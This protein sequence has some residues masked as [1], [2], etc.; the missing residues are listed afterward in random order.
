MK[1]KIKEFEAVSGDG[2]RKKYILNFNP[3]GPT[4]D[5]NGTIYNAIMPGTVL[6]D[7]KIKNPQPLPKATYAFKI[8]GV[9]Y[10]IV[11]SHLHGII[12]QSLDPKTVVTYSG[13]NRSDLVVKIVFGIALVV[14]LVLGILLNIK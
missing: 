7:E 9:I 5:D 10:I 1:N 8:D 2:T 3:E 6:K 14:V 11:Y 12:I 13:K 4:I